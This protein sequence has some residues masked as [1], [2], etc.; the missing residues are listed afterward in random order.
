MYRSYFFS[1]VITLIVV[2][3]SCSKGKIDEIQTINIDVNSTVKLESCKVISKIEFIPLQ[4]TDSSLLGNIRQMIFTDEYIIVSDNKSIISVFDE[5]GKFISNSKKRYGQ[6]PEEYA[7]LMGLSYNKY[8]NNIEIL[9]PNYLLSYDVRFNYQ[10]KT[11][12]PVQK[13]VSEQKRGQFFEGIYALINE[14]YILLPTTVSSDPYRIIFFDANTNE[15][16]KEMAY[17]D[18][19]LAALTQQVQN[20]NYFNDSVLSFSPHAFSYYYYTI[21]LKTYKLNKEFKLDF[22]NQ[23]VKPEDLASYKSE[24]EKC[25]YLAFNSK[26]PLPLRTFFNN[27]YIVSIIRKEKDYYTFIK[28]TK[29]STEIVIKNTL[30]IGQ[31][32]LPFFEA[33]TDNVLYA[34]INPN[35]LEQFVFSDLLD[36]QGQLLL[37]NVNPE[38]NPLIVKYYLK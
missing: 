10:G 33:L 34:R 32:Q 14:K 20:I 26:Y 3:G 7:I 9:T 5:K 11:E 6:G 22:G 1:C 16:I 35:E 15:V 29:A 31:K 27:N 13:K 25:D 30:N 17:A 28:S 4:T 12:L 19:V 24:R 18:R 2:L 21:D 8:K 23:S 36:E 38:D 37:K